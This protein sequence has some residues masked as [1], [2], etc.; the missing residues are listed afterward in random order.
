MAP[1]TNTCTALLLMAA[2][3]SAQL[4]SFDFYNVG[5]WVLTVAL[6]LGYNLARAKK[7]DTE[8]NQYLRACLWVIR[9]RPWQKRLSEPTL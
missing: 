5:R 9:E 4:G 8:S 2:S 7:L 6:A 1:T 3:A